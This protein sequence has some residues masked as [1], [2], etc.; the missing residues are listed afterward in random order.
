MIFVDLETT[1]LDARQCAIL[2]IGIANV[3]RNLELISFFEGVVTP[4][5]EDSPLWTPW[6][7]QTHKRTGL[8]EHCKETGSPLDVV[9]SSAISYLEACGVSHQ[10]ERSKKPPMFGNSLRLDRD[11]L[12]VHAPKL[13]SM[14]HYR[15]GD[16]SSVRVIADALGLPQWPGA[17]RP[18]SEIAHR[19][20]ADI[21][22]SI[23]QLRWYR[24]N[25]FRAT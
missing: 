19:G 18:E 4:P 5:P 7:L 13:A 20:I 21:V 1:G 3:D 23:D 22:A 17:N 10:T 2:E 9:V 16:V 8:L 6:A 25:I 11:F 15:N 12:E 14:F 24:D